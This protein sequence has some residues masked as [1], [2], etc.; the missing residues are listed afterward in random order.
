MQSALAVLK[1][2]FGYSEFRPNQ[3]KVIS[4][5]LNKQDTVAL[6]P[7]GGGKSMCYQL[8]ALLFDGLTVVISPLI[9]LMKDQVDALNMNGVA[10]AFLNS[11]QSSAEQS[12]IIEQVRTG[13]LQLLY[14]APERLLGHD[15]GLLDFLEHQNMALFAID[16]AHCISQW[17]H[18]FR[19][20]YLQLR[21]LKQR[22]PKVPII[23][24]TATA[25]PRTQQDILDK[26][27]LHQ[28]KVVVGSFNRP[29]IYYEIQPKQKSFDK[30]VHFLRKHPDD[31]GI[32]YCLSRN[33]TEKI[34]ADLKHNGFSALPYHAG[35]PRET[36]AK[37][38]ELFIRD[39]VKIIVATIAFGMGIDKSNVRFVVH[40]D[41]PK[42]IEGYYQETG[43]AGRD[44]IDSKAL[45]FFSRGDALK[46]QGFA[47]VEGDPQQSAMML[48]KLNQMV[49]YCESR[50]CR[51]QYLLEYFGES[52]PGDC[53]TC[54]VCQTEY[55]EFD[56]T[57]IAQKALS[58]VYRLK[59]SFGS[60]YVIDFLRGSKSEKI[61]PWH[62]TLPTYGVGKEFSKNAWKSY[63]R[64]LL[65]LG[66]LGLS[67]GQYPILK[68]TT[69]STAVLKG[70]ERVVLIEQEEIELPTA[71]VSDVPTEANLFLE[72]KK[73][74]TQ[75][76]RKLG[77]PPYI[78]FSD[79]TL[80]EL[81]KYLPLT[82]DDLDYI[83]GF[84]TIK[85]E[86]HGA[87]FLEC[88]QDFA[89]EYKV[90]SRMHLKEQP[91]KRKKKRASRK[92]S[93]KASKGGSM[94]ESLLLFKSGLSTDE[95][96]QKRGFK[97]STIQSHLATF[98]G[99]GTLALSELVDE[100]KVPA[101]RESLNRLGGKILSVVKNDLGKDY[102]YGEIKAVL[103]TLE[104]V[105][106]EPQDS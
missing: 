35:L 41:L 54:D 83:S 46:L 29:N 24:L 67:D 56:G 6:M 63:L 99:D 72:L 16:E 39:E 80:Q 44:G 69:K 36:R 91:A 95:I 50:K 11:T 51:R 103:A 47:E 58:A 52:H 59:E 104:K 4:S 65:D 96:A 97:P 7:T 3:E 30:L 78:V 45:L 2:Q 88:V 102:T 55:I 68:L 31:S 64:S 48:N 19:P 70:T 14:M 21:K 17:G 74:R 98:V 81:A 105:A 53:G 100:S 76:A 49:D 60:G 79:A 77:V 22:F 61:K 34:A 10:A 86:R 26:L 12:S 25:D 93:S 18:D 87:A 15:A 66:Y 43:R 27:Q 75:I 101:I 13:Q 32:I 42:N 28:P 71:E 38:Q 84:G 23:A 8:P 37:N 1:K 73:L 5:I 89:A 106:E 40:M 20:E 94:Q 90:E 92:K 9:A 57:E 33:S 85:K 82:S 62:K